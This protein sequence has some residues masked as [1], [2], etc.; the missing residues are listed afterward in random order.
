MWQARTGESSYDADRDPVHFDAAAP[1]VRAGPGKPYGR[2]EQSRR[3]RIATAW[4]SVRPGQTRGA[5]LH[6]VGGSGTTTSGS[7]GGTCARLPSARDAR[8]LSLRPARP[9]QYHPR[10]VRP[11]RPSPSWGWGRRRR[12]HHPPHPSGPAPVPG[13]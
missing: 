11:P 4:V 9:H 6:A 8:S 10:P 13:R 7:G 12:H 5:A 1:H 2:A 3:A